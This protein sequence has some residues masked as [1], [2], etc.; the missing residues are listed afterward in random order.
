MDA[1]KGEFLSYRLTSQDLQ[2]LACQTIS[3]KQ[4]K[5]F[6]AKEKDMK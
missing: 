4:Q 2:S 6:P 1:L 3:T 5:A